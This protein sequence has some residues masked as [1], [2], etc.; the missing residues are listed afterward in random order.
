VYLIIG[1]P[2]ESIGAFQEIETPPLRG[3]SFTPT[4]APGADLGVVELAFDA[5]DAPAS[6]TAVTVTD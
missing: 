6:F 1:V 3:V 4:G 2:P 5:E